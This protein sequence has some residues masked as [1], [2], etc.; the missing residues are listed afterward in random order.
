MIEVDEQGFVRDI[1]AAI[2]AINQENK[3]LKKLLNC[4]TVHNMK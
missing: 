1:K 3:S 4:P 2:D